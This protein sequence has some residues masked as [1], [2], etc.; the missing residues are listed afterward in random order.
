MIDDGVLYP[1]QYNYS[2][3]NDETYAVRV[4]VFHIGI[5]FSQQFIDE[6]R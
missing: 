6:D 2:T 4:S 3:Y 5:L 1:K